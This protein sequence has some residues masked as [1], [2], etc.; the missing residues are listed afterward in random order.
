MQSE[1]FYSKLPLLTLTPEFKTRYRSMKNN[2]PC[3]SKAINLTDRS[4]TI[5]IIR[6][7]YLSI[8]N[9]RACG[10]PQDFAISR[11]YGTIEQITK[12]DT[13]QLYP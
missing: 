2:M 7:V 4:A 3:E 9:R 12:K 11:S 10:K 5:E 6:G 8:P 1:A 13:Y